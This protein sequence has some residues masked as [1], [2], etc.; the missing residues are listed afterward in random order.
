MEVTGHAGYDQSGRDIVCAACS[1][2][3]QALAAALGARLVG[4]SGA[5]GGQGPAQSGAAQTPVG[6]K[7]RA[8]EDGSC[9]PWGEEPGINA[10]YGQAAGRFWL[11]CGAASQRAARRDAMFDMAKTAFRLLE[12]TYPEHVRLIDDLCQD[13]VE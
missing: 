2:I 12:G 3:V 6:S 9:D 8:A 10:H 7:A 4:D 5:Q 1:I 11:V 13:M